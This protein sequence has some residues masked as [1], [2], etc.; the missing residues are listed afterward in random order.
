MKALHSNYNRGH[1]VELQVKSNFSFLEGASHP[2]ELLSEAATL[3]YEALALTDRHTVSGLVRAH[4]AAKESGVRLISGSSLPLF[5]KREEEYDPLPLTLLAYPISRPGYGNMCSLLTT[6]KLRAPKGQCYVTLEDFAERSKDLVA[7]LAPQSGFSEDHSTILPLLKE[8]FCDN[9]LF[10]ALQANYTTTD[11]SLSLTLKS[12][13]KEFEIPFV[14]T[15]NV[16]YHSPKRRIL[17]DA[18]SCIRLGCT[19]AEAGYALKANSELYLKPPKEMLRLFRNMPEAT[20]RTV[21]IAELTTGFSLDMVKYE[22]PHEIC[23]NDKSPSEYL[24]ELVRKGAKER[25]PAGLPREVANQIVHELNLVE[26]LRYE[27]YFLTVY[28]IVSFAKREGILCQ[29]RGAAANSAICYVLGITAVDPTQIK[30]LFERFISKERNE[31]PDIDVDFEHERREEVI[32]YIYNRFGRDRAAIISEVVTYRSK[33]AIRDVGKVFSLSLETV[34]LLIRLRS[35]APEN[36]VTDELLL[37]NE[38]DPTDLAIKHTLAISR[39]LKGFPRHLSQHVGGFIVSETPLYEIAPIENA[40]M[41]NRTIL[42]W[43]KED[44]DNM[45]MLKTDILALGMLTCIR[46]AFDLLN[47]RNPQQ[48][49][50]LYSLPQDDKKTYDMICKA[51]TLGVFQIESRAQMSM[52]PRLRP[53]VFY[54]LVIEVAIVRP[55]PIQGGMVHPFLRRRAGKEPVIYPDKRIEKVLSRTMGV[56]IFQEQ[57]MEIATVAAGFTPGQADELRRAMASWKR[58]KNLLIKFHDRLVNGM[59]QNGYKIEFAEQIFLQIQGFGEYG[60]PQSHSASFALLAYASAWLKCHHPAAF[61][62]ALLN[63]QPMGFYLP[64]QII[65]DAKRHGVKVL[66]VDV[67]K[68]DWDCTLEGEDPPMLRLGFRVIRGT[69]KNEVKKIPQAKRPFVSPDKLWRETNVSASQLRIL[70]KGDA[71][72]SMGLDRQQ[73]LWS[74]RKLS[75]APL[76]LFDRVENIYQDKEEAPLPQISEQLHIIMDYRSTSLSLK[77]HPFQFLREHLTLRGVLTLQEFKDESKETPAPHGS[78]RTIAGIVLVRQRPS[79]A[80]GTMFMTLEDETGM[81]NLIIR[82]NILQRFPEEILDSVFMV[83]RG[84][85]Q[86]LESVVHLI[87]EEAADISPRQGEL[88]SYS[89]DFR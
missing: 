32:Q 73:A 4:V 9:N 30:L 55:G 74:L 78:T 14:A 58:N 70:A 60:F 66:P 16:H 21:E 12:L 25:Y 28:D 72:R 68:S 46:K 5:K 65:Q 86:K 34:E 81:A 49:V 13:A 11:R 1:Y 7:I 17:Q 23:P 45:G 24:R 38:L 67:N 40:S 56:P 63:S 2:G 54:D 71:F 41:E 37:A 27:K 35:R 15:N 76:P 22:Y 64:S 26:E 10:L 83:G 44:I 48:Q 88:E 82:P 33:S 36:I 6:G 87:L 18:I 61:A 59:L 85:V 3:G 29:G 51:D 53:R 47:I 42:E 62:A 19:I 39:I 43:D 50:A 31:P 20:R 77:G 69:I 8:Y 89:R 57:V 84:R 75:D 80:R 52:L 79:T